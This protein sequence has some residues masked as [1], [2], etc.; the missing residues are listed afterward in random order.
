MRT[1]DTTVECNFH[2]VLTQFLFA[3]DSNVYRPWGA[4]V[5]ITS[6]S[7]PHIR[8][9]RTSLHYATPCQ[10]ADIRSWSVTRTYGPPVTADEQLQ[11]V[12]EEAEAY[13]HEFGIPTDW[14]E[15]IKESDHLHIEF[16]PKRLKGI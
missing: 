10:A 12:T 13:C 6:G 9:S 2:P 4:E 1:K 14:I 16:Q 3:I 11:A 8:H 7:E 15:V 5:V